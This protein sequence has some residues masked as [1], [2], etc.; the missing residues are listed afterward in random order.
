MH[1]ATGPTVVFDPGDGLLAAM[2]ELESAG[3]L[4]RER[5]ELRFMDLVRGGVAA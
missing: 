1:S 3:K 2:L 4:V 5:G